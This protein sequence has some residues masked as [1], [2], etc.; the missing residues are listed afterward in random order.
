MLKKIGWAGT[1]LFFVFIVTTTAVLAGD[2]NQLWSE[3]LDRHVRQ[4]IVD[5]QGFKRD[6]AE[7]DGYLEFLKRIDPDLLSEQDQLAL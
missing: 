7:F 1:L 4:G 5:Y 6:E 3:L 2:E